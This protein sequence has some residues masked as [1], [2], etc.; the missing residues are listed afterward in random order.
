MVVLGELINMF[1][2]LFV[3][4]FFLKRKNVEGQPTFKDFVLE[5][6]S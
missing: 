2:N 4:F 1:R 6:S 5:M 3:W